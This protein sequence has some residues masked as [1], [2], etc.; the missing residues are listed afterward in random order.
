MLKRTL[1][2]LVD[3]EAG[4]EVSNYNGGVDLT[5]TEYEVNET[6]S[7]EG[8]TVYEPRSEVTLMLED[9]EVQA[10]IDTLQSFLTQK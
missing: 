1:L 6:A 5:L 4:V 10:I 9:E 8:H 7:T 3:G 2:Q